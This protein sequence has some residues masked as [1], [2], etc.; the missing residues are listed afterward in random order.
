MIIEKITD[1]RATV[2]MDTEDLLLI[3]EVFN[4]K[5]T[6]IPQIAGRDG[7]KF[8]ALMAIGAAFQA[9]ALATAHMPERIKKG[10]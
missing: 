3:A 5:H 4:N 7:M 9:A 8:A 1:G 2:E 10:R 6:Q